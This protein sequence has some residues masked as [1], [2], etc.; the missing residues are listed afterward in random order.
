MIHDVFI[1][2]SP[3]DKDISETILYELERQGVKGWVAPQDIAPRISQEET[4]NDAIKTSKLLVVILSANSQNSNQILHDVEQAVFNEVLVIPF[5]VENI[6]L[7]GNLAYYISTEYWLDAITPPLEKHIH[8][9]GQTIKQLL[10]HERQA[11][12]KENS[13]VVSQEQAKSTLTHST[14]TNP[15]TFGNP[16][17]EPARFYGREEDIRQIVNRLRSSAHESTSVVG[18]R[19]IGKTSLLKYLENSEVAVRLG[20]SP[21]KYCM[22]YIDF[23]GLTDITPQRFWQRVLHKME[24]TICLPYLEPEIQQVRKQGYFDLF[25]LEDLFEVIG[26]SGLTTVLLMDEFEYVTQNPNFGPDFFGGLRALAIHQSLPLVTATRREL[27]DLCHS[28]ELKG[29]PFFNIFANIVLRPFSRE[30]VYEML[31]GYLAETDLTFSL[32]EKELIVGLGG[33][34]PFFAQ[35]AGHYLV[36]AKRKGFKGD[37]LLQDVVANF[38]A[39]SDS[40]F[41][42]MW[43]HSSESEKITLLA[44]ISLNRQKPSKKTIPNLE[45]LA[46]IHSHAHLD[47]PELVKRGLLLENRIEGTFSLLSPSLERWIAREIYAVPGEEESQASVQ[48]WLKSGGKQELEATSNFLRK[49]KK[50]YWSIVGGLAVDLSME[51]VGAVTWQILTKAVL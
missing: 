45:N 32:R 35:M 48:E 49:F 5:C 3:N 37:A 41:T 28:E 31:D 18:E 51:L 11:D 25:D 43:S 30:D 9:L 34:Y 19:R 46:A 4:I 15:F 50:K 6:E 29:S 17:R 20:L 42:Y 8:K 47:V 40:H 14:N 36:E 13:F 2:S 12:S 23:Q 39:Q 16:I 24:R 21:D 44:V 10:K 22:V 7:S 27:V 1:S 26:D 33:G 38:D